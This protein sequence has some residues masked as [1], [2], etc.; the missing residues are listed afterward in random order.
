M[1]WNWLKDV[2]FPKHRIYYIAL[3][4]FVIAAATWLALRFFEII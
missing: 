2:P 4:V 3:K 1:N